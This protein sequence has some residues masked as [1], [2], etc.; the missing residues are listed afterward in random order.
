MLNGR[1]VIIYYKNGCLALYPDDL[2]LLEKKIKE[3]EDSN[4]AALIEYLEEEGVII[5]DIIEVQAFADNLAPYEY[6]LL[7]LNKTIHKFH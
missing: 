7:V 4:Q 2:L 6:A 3:G 5:D 1:C